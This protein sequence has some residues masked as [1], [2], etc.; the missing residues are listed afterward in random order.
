MRKILALSVHLFTSTGIV[1]G[2][3]AML[4][5]T[6]HDFKA[7]I[8]WLFVALVI[9]GVDGTLARYFKVKE[10]LPNFDGKTIDYVVDFATYAIIP[11]FFFYFAEKEGTY[12]LPDSLRLTSAIMILLVSSMYYGKEGMVT[13]DY[14]FL[15]FPVLWNMVACYLY[16]VMDFSPQWNFFWIVVCSILHFVPLKFLYPSRTPKFRW[17]N[18]LM[19]ILFINSCGILVWLYPTKYL[20]IQWMAWVSA[21]YFGIMAIYHT[22]IDP[23]TKI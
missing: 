7:A 4:A 19:T 14:Y 20:V 22:Y 2:F 15:G 10:V 1:A 16:F 17:L 12:I 23:E 11:A 8:L 21:A 5:I 3:M 13:C 6:T 9:D 18:I